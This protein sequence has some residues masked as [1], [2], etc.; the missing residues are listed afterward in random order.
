MNQESVFALRFVVKDLAKVRKAIETMNKNL[1]SMQKNADKTKASLEKMNSSLGKG[2][3]SL[4]KFALSYFTISK[5]IGTVF[6]KTAEAVQISNM[7]Q[8]AG[9]AQGA[10]GRLGKALRAYG[11]DAR[12]AGAAYA[13]LTNIIGK[14][15][16]G[17]GISE[18]VQRV[19]AMYGI[20]FNFGNIGKDELMTN[21]AKSMHRLH[22]KGDQWAINQIASAYG[23][24]SAMANFLAEKGGSWKKFVNTKEYKDLNR[25]ELQKILDTEDEM[26]QVME[27]MSRKVVQGLSDILD[28]L[29]KKFGLTPD[30]EEKKRKEEIRKDEEEKEKLRKKIIEE[31]NRVIKLAGITP[32][33]NL[34]ADYNRALEKTRIE[35][36]SNK[37]MSLARYWMDYIKNA[38]FDPQEMLQ[39]SRLVSNIGG[40][41]SSFPA[42]DGI[43]VR[44]E[45]GDVVIENKSGQE[46]MATKGKQEVTYVK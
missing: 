26:N 14:A 10:I 45:F 39:A 28:W 19:N 22:G 31:K 12:S 46:I 3:K 16:H 44:V 7:A 15:R 9:V 25:S 41:I 24:D 20:G 36:I 42:K 17:F 32:T 38:N 6:N 35:A 34:D 8:Q 5:I 43:T 27:N 40:K 37:N 2:A 11:G 1:E 4:A 21:I 30:E 29:K 18:D 13:N 23:I 33:G